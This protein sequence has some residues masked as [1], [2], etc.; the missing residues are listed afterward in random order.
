MLVAGILQE[1]G[2]DADPR[3][4]VA[5]TMMAYALSSLLTGN[6]NLFLKSRALFEATARHMFLAVGIL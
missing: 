6:S 3:D 4:I 2:E 1:L 5:T